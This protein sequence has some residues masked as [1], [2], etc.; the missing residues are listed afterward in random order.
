MKDRPSFSQNDWESSVD[1][2]L[3]VWMTDVGL[4]VVLGLLALHMLV[5]VACMCVCSCMCKCSCVLTHSHVPE[6][7][8]V[9]LVPHQANDDVGVRMVSQLLQPPLYILEG[10]CAHRESVV[11]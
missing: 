2:L 5:C 10:H 1:T 9:T 6:V 4:C 3:C 7:L 11:C 8:Q